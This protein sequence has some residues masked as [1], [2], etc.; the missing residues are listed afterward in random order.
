[1]PAAR[2]NR[3]SRS[4]LGPRSRTLAVR[5]MTRV[6]TEQ[7]ALDHPPVD[8]PRPRTR[9][10]C[11][12]RAPCPWCGSEVV[13]RILTREDDCDR[14]H[15][16]T[17]RSTESREEGGV[18]SQWGRD[19]TDVAGEVRL[20]GD[21]GCEGGESEK[22][23]DHEL[24]VQAAP[25]RD[26]RNARVQRLDG[27]AAAVLEPESSRVEVARS[28]GHLGVP[29]MDGT[30]GVREVLCGHGAQ[31]DG[32]ALTRPDRQQRPLRAEQLPLGDAEAAGAQQAHIACPRCRRRVRYRRGVG[33]AGWAW[34]KHAEGEAQARLDA[35]QGGE[36]ASALNRCRPCAWTSCKHH[37]YL[38]V[39]P[40]TGSIKFNF[41][42]LEPW[43]LAETCALDV[44]D[45][46]G[47]I[48]DVLGTL[49]NVTRERARQLELIALHAMKR[50]GVD[51]EV[52]E[53]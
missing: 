36:D 43:E 37:L 25:A 20:R 15:R 35:V 52:L 2:R 38:D 16:A 6:E 31:A 11:V 30:T 39:N 9:G 48:L 47:V 40:E 50:Q 44:A 49:M 34:D 46:G 42:A 12:G 33:G 4:V 53:R 7:G 41:P 32:P 5:R 22:G 17:V 26:V 27:D 14:S 23:R 1:M 18:G 10:E 28:S 51:L 3:T 8:E 24:R 21:E 29:E 13:M 45:A 19:R